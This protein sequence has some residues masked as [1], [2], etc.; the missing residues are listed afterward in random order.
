MAQARQS[1]QPVGGVDEAGAVAACCL[2]ADTPAPDKCCAA[3]AT[4]QDR[5]CASM[6]SVSG[7]CMAFPI[8]AGQVGPGRQLFTSLNG[9][10][11]NMRPEMAC[12]PSWAHSSWYGSQQPAAKQTVGR[13]HGASRIG[14]HIHDRWAHGACGNCTFGDRA[15]YKMRTTSLRIKEYANPITPR[16]QRSDH[17]T[18]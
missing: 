13:I 3:D 7:R 2:A 15:K 16:T 5:R 14:N 18:F 10:Q 11:V 12:G 4:W 9:A 17:K 8:A 6:C 1:W